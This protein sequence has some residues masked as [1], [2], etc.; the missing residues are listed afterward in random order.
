[1]ERE[2]GKKVDKH[3]VLDEQSSVEVRCSSETFGIELGYPRILNSVN[4]F[5]LNVK[6]TLN[7]DFIRP[8]SLT[9]KDPSCYTNRQPPMSQL[10][11]G[12]KKVQ[13]TGTLVTSVRY[14]GS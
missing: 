7:P 5:E 14:T 8:L 1:M 11:N 3:V 13:S 2:R 12:H 9:R 10:S 4:H 6:I